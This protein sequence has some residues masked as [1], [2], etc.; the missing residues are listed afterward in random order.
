[1]NLSQQKR[2]RLLNFIKELKSNNSFDEKSLIE[3]N[4][5]ENEL[6]GKKYGLV[7]EEHKKNVDVKMKD[8]IPIFTEVKD[9]E[10]LTDKGAEYNFLIKG[11]NLHSLYLLKKTHKGCIDIIYIDIKSTS[12]IQIHCR[13]NCK[14]VA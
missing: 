14:T 12:L 2:E 7:W 3:L 8:N 10:I 5:I 1:M 13:H 6:N 9:K 4:E 11:D